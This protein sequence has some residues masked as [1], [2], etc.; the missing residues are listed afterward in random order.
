MTSLVWVLEHSTGA[1]MEDSPEEEE[2]T[3]G[4]GVAQS[5]GKE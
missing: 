4:G 1:R 3:R 5:P 2:G